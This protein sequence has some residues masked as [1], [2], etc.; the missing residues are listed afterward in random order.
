MGLFRKLL[1]KAARSANRVIVE[2][3][4]PRVKAEDLLPYK[5]NE[6]RVSS[7]LLFYYMI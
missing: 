4:L 3:A 7:L 6:V 5:P 2:K 1:R